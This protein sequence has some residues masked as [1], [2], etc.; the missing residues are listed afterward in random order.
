MDSFIKIGD[1][2]KHYRL[3]KGLS[4]DELAVG[5]C[6]RKY[7]SQLE[8]HQN[9]PT[10]YIINALSLKLG[11]NLYDAYAIMLK[12]HDIE[13]HKKIATLNQAIAEGNF[14]KII[15]LIETY[16]LLP[17]FQQGEPLQY[18]KY[19]QSVYL[20]NTTSEFSKA[21]AIAKS[22]FSDDPLSDSEAPQHTYLSNVELALLNFI[23]VNTCRLGNLQEGKRYFDF[24]YNHLDYLFNTNHYVA[25]RNNHFELRFFAN[26]IYNDFYFFH[27]TDD[28]DSQR[29][30][31]IL[32]LLKDLHSHFDLPELLLCK[33]VLLLEQNLI[34]EAQKVYS[35][36]HELGIYL[37]SEAKM[38]DL[39]KKIL[40][41]IP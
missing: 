13:T 26:L 36:A 1:I 20:S 6:S 29:I 2:I 31:V 9:I 16:Q 27:K 19:G 39:E 12:H 8:A 4:Q 18:I 21:I 10:L 14:D 25:N 5:I 11:I 3:E 30:D 34:S 15:A 38:Q 33:T 7:I 28:F 35:L 22:A 41:Y 37:Y 40:P 17:E 32:E 24:L 23:A